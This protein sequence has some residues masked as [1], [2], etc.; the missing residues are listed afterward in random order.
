[1]TSLRPVLAGYRLVRS[2]PCACLP[3]ICVQN[4]PVAHL[5]IVVWRLTYTVCRP[6]FDLLYE[7][8]FDFPLPLGVR[9]FC[10]WALHFFWP[11]SWLPPFPDCL[12]FLPYH[13]IISAVMTQ[14]CWASLGLPFILS[15]SGLTWP[16]VFL[17]I[18]SYILFVFLLGIL[19]PFAFFGLPYPFY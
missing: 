1:M 19:S 8:L 14:S 6:F 17:L 18:G 2:G 9:L 4:L 3:S 5:S 11:I 10:Y 12:N 16:L 13:S 15:L 7:L